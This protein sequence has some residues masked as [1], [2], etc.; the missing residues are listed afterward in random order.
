MVFMNLVASVT[1]AEILSAYPSLGSMYTMTYLLA[2]KKIS[3]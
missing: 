1:L 2:P 3:K